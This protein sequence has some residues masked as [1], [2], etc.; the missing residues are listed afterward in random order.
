MPEVSLH[1]DIINDNIR[2]TEHTPLIT[3]WESQLG[4]VEAPL[5]LEGELPGCHAP[6]RYHGASL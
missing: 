6:H 4:M 3:S 2:G 1:A 5:T